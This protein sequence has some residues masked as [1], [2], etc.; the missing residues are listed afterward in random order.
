M[1]RAIRYG[2]WKLI[3][4]PQINKTQLFDLEEDPFEQNDLSDKP[5]SATQLVTL[6]V[7]LQVALQHYGDK[8]P[9]TA[10]NPKPAAWSPAPEK[11][12]KKKN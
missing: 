4:Y 1:Q 2:R 9:Y 8:C 5:K 7:D 6:S 3:R 11:P 12:R 10:L